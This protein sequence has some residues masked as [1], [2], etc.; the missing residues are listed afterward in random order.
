MEK[1]AAYVLKEHINVLK[2][3]SKYY[4]M[5]NML[6]AYNRKYKTMIFV[7]GS[8]LRNHT[9]PD[10]ILTVHTLG[11]HQSKMFIPSKNVDQIS[12]EI[13]FLIAIC[14]PTGDKWQSK[15]LFP[16]SLGPYLSIGRSVFDCCLSGVVPQCRTGSVRYLCLYI[17]LRLYIDG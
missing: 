15:T 4:E 13:E 2:E 7:H 9:T 5:I 14:H 16:A 17:L 1:N 11:R 3:G 8:F 6:K 10:I 12:L